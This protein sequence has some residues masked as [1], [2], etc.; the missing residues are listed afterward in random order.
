MNMNR[1]AVI[2]ITVLV[3]AL[4]ASGCGGGR[5]AAKAPAG[6]KTVRFGGVSIK[7]PGGWVMK[8]TLVDSAVGFV[9]PGGSGR[10]LYIRLS[11]KKQADPSEFDVITDGTRSSVKEAG[12]EVKVDDVDLPGAK[13][14]VRIV[15]QVPAE[16]ETPA[17]RVLALVALRS[18]GALVDL[19]AAAPQGAK[20]KLATDAVVD[21]LKLD[22]G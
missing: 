18:D 3:G 20:D 2:L 21:S 14:A 8:P 9:P 6:Y 17:G 11:V 1:S 7:A 16:A 10:T 22:S 15:A 5:E 13:R 19:S 4:L 12:G